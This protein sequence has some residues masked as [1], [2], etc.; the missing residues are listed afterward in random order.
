MAK[1][2]R[3]K[4]DVTGLGRLS[5]V[6][7]A[8]CPTQ[9]AVASSF[10]GFDAAIA[11]IPPIPTL[12]ALLAATAAALAVARLGLIAPPVRPAARTGGSALFETPSEVIGRLP[13]EALRLAFEN[14]SEGLVLYDAEER[15]VM[16][17][18]RYA[19]IYHLS[20]N[21]ARVGT[22]FDTLLAHWGAI[23]LLD[24]DDN[25]RKRTEAA[26]VLGPISIELNLADGRII[27]LNECSL[28]GGG[29]VA[30]HED[31]TDRRR[32]EDHVRRLAASDP[33]TGLLNRFT[34]LEAFADRLAP[35]GEAGGH[36]ACP[37]SA[38]LLLDI[39]RFKKINDLFG[40]QIGDALLIALAGRLRETLGSGAILA[41]LGGDEF[42]VVLPPDDM[43]RLRALADDLVVRLC[44]PYTF[45]HIAAEVRVS[46]GIARA[47]DHGCEPN[48]LLAR[49][50]RAL[51][52][53][54]STPGNAV[55][56][57][58]PDLDARENE[59]RE[60]VRELARALDH[61]GL[62][63]AFQPIVHTAS[64]EIHGA[65]ALLRWNHPRLG[66][67]SPEHI[68]AVAEESGLI[69]PLGVWILET[70]LR[71]A[72]GWPDS[73]CIS[74]NLSALQFRSETI[75]STVIRALERTGVAPHRLE[76]EVTETVLCEAEAAETMVALRATGVRLA[77]DDFGTGYASLAYL[78]RFP[79]DRIK[80]DRS[81]VAD[82]E[83]RPQSR[84]IVEAVADLARSLHLQVVAEGVET[85]AE[86]TV[87]RT[88]GCRYA[89]GWLF[90]RPVSADAFS[91]LLRAGDAT[92]AHL[93]LA[94]A[95]G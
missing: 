10:E 59:R 91:E 46:I 80:I 32:A 4:V 40:Q 82:A 87:V 93:R 63:L 64:R 26:R 28:P 33:L 8:L 51:Q 29:W 92:T 52:V 61:G 1:W 43:R 66:P 72:A 23:G 6:F 69:H 54:K 78:L 68:V 48:R 7:A 94:Q 89:Q 76:L 47:P 41:R 58:T 77:L 84:A 86:R 88:A 31:I 30:T 81:F 90:G 53:A 37:P 70:A 56:Y 62:E 24:A 34:F 60:L 9:V 3:W 22:P 18:R 79:F 65:E 2:W 17:N 35:V 11:W 85:E 21:L 50:D 42:A 57:Y 14:M 25:R 95:H 12:T 38:V 19:E 49:A 73:V 20:P 27:E 13:P 16:C 71:V 15:L 39:D 45:G 75:V 83:S 55:V 5:V 44:R 67:I 36:T 74:V